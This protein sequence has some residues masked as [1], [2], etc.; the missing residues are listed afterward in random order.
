MSRRSLGSGWLR[1]GLLLVALGLA[2]LH[3]S[4]VWPLGFVTLI[5]LAID[6]ARLRLSLPTRASR[7][8]RP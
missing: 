4:G 3:A 1:F 6:D 2:L 5:D 8:P 7:P